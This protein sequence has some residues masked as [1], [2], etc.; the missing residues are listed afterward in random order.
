MT[1]TDVQVHKRGDFIFRQYEEY[2]TKT[3]E[4]NGKVNENNK[5]INEVLEYA[6]NQILDS[7]MKKI[8]QAAWNFINIQTEITSIVQQADQNTA[9]SGEILST[10][11]AQNK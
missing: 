1:P 8:T 6:A 11:E 4:M 3:D 10:L 7:N 9:S 5:S 2:H